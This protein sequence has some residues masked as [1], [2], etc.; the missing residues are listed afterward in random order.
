MTQRI[1]CRHATQN[2]IGQIDKEEMLQS[3]Y[4]NPRPSSL[5]INSIIGTE[6]AV[7]YL[8]MDT[9]W[10]FNAII[11]GGEAANEMVLVCSCMGGRSDMPVEVTNIPRSLGPPN[12]NSP[13]MKQAKSPLSLFHK[14]KVNYFCRMN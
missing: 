3:H 7:T 14:M 10:S 13:Y 2:N 12:K 6:Y 5:P 9:N 4:S 11:Y 1:T 8:C